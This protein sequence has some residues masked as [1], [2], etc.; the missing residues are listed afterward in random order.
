MN[1]FE[2]DQVEELCRRFN[3]PNRRLIM[4]NG[5]RQA[6][7]TTIALQALRRTE[8][9]SRYLAADDPAAARIP[10]DF[11]PRASVP[12]SMQ[13]APDA[14]W[15]IGQ[16]ERA[17]RDADRAGG[18]IL[19]LDE[20]QLIPDWSRI[21]KGLWDADRRNQSTL[22]VVILGSM[23]HYLQR[24]LSESLVGRFSNVHVRHWSLK[25]MGQ[26][27]GLGLEEFVYFGGY[28]GP[29]A[30]SPAALRDSVEF[31]NHW[32][33]YVR[34]AIAVPTIRKDILALTDVRKPTLLQ[35]FLEVGASHSGQIL[36]FNKMI[37]QL[38]DAGNTTTLAGYLRLL[39]SVGLIT[40]IQNFGV[41]PTT[42]RNLSP[43][44]N[45][46]NTALMSAFSDYTF[47]QARADRT[48]WRRM[49]ESAVGAHLINSASLRTKVYYWRRGSF[50]VDFV[51]KRGPDIVGIEVGVLNRPRNPGGMN[52][53]KDAFGQAATLLVGSDGIPLEGF[54][55]EP[56]D[57]WI[58]SS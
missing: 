5:P 57:Y 14:E 18:F 46:L 51:L 7:K 39:E 32:I 31:Q 2:R 38:T 22:Q 23:P 17:R 21:V 27:F 50:E 53:F 47:D 48:Q 16:W 41:S 34:E 13:I 54:L 56:A 12:S 42:R 25:E 4:L 33:D 40:G 36:S 1:E 29:F 20:I 43:K 9:A 28:P 52:A 35:S 58:D 26:G 3:E 15:L 11:G 55:S 45:V 37:G 49:I 10:V 6:G 44:L 8:T 24:G 30:G 19:V